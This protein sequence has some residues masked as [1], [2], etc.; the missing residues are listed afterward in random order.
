VSLRARYNSES[1]GLARE[2]GTAVVRP[3]RM[4]EGLGG[5]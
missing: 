1:E 5:K 4:V 3:S 2:G